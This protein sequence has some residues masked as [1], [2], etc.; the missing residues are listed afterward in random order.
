MWADLIN[1]DL[2]N[3]DLKQLQHMVAESV[4]VKED[5]VTIDPKEKGIRKALNLGHTVGHAFEAMALKRER[6]ILHG[7]AVAYGL[8]C[9]LYLS[10]VKTGFQQRRCIRQ[11]ISSRRTMDN[12][13]SHAMIMII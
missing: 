8:I 5:I 4:K 7:Y 9:E 11:S 10:A 2:N 6:P 12:L 3:P 1:F 13:I